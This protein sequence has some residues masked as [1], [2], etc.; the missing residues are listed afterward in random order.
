MLRI[1]IV[2]EW[3]DRVRC[4]RLGI[5]WVRDIKLTISTLGLF[6]LFNTIVAIAIA[7]LLQQDLCLCSGRIAFPLLFGLG[8]SRGRLRRRFVGGRSR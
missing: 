8:D 3:V 5:S 4:I 2:K 1:R 6:L 7:G